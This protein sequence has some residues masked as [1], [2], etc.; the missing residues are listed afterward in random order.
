MLPRD[1]FWTGNKFTLKCRIIIYI[2][3]LPVLLLLMLSRVRKRLRLRC[4]TGL[5]MCQC[6]V[7]NNYLHN[8]FVT[9][10]F[11]VI[12]SFFFFNF[13]DFPWN[14]YICTTVGNKIVL[15]RLVTSSNL[16][17]HNWGAEIIGIRL[18]VS[19][20]RPNVKRMKAHKVRI[21][22][23]LL[24]LSSILYKKICMVIKM[25]TLLV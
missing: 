8:F 2:L 10:L 20:W 14:S 13:S 15:E 18:F 19:T 4:L 6:C 23:S 16:F 7:C 9:F 25:V 1:S 5:W 21:L 24:I 3:S 22:W 17:L 11:L 12:Q